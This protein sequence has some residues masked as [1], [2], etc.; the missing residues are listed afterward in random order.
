MRKEKKSGRNA[1]AYAH[2]EQSGTEYA[3]H[4]ILETESH[5]SNRNAR[6]KNLAHI[7]EVGV[8]P[9]CEEAFAELREHGPEHHQSGAYR[10]RMNHNVEL[11][12]L[13]IRQIHSENL[14]EYLEM[15]ARTYRKI[16]RKS[17]NYT[18]NKSI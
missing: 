11:K 9:E 3:F 16:F 8:T 12:I 15:T 6:H 18:Q 2:Y 1:E 10:G 13:V 14:F 17:L 7:V 5:Y 4:I